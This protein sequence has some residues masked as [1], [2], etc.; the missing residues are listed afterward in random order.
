MSD[1]EELVRYPL[2]TEYPLWA[3][4]NSQYVIHYERHSSVKTRISD[5]Y[6]TINL[7][8]VRKRTTRTKE[9]SSGNERN[10]EGIELHHEFVEFIIEAFWKH[11]EISSFHHEISSFHHWSFLKAP[12]IHHEISSFHHWS[13][14]KVHHFIIDFIIS[15]WRE[16][17]QNDE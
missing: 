17:G 9:L 7:T 14:L 16:R 10:E 3:T 15:S 6:S 11:A 2:S 1:E 13:F 5:F 4:R 12:K 8:V